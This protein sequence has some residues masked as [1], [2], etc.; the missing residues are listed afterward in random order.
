MA[1]TDTETARQSSLDRYAVLSHPAGRE[2]Q[3]LVEL[4]AQ[5]CDVPTAAINIVTRDRQHQIATAG[6]D[7]SVCSRDDSMCA[8]VLGEDGPVVVPDA[9]ADPRFA[10]NAFVNGDIG[11]VRFYAS[12]PLVTPEGTMLGRLCVFDDIARELSPRQQDALT[13]LAAQIMDVLELRY[14]T[15]ALE[16]SLREL[17]EVRDALRRSNEHLTLFA[18]QVSHDLRTPLTA[19]LVNAEVLAGEPVIRDNADATE[20]VKAVQTAGHR[21][22]AMIEEMLTFALEG[23]RL[24]VVETDLRRVVDLV[25]SDIAPML[26]RDRADVRVGDLPR[27]MGDHDLLY[28]VVLNLLTNAVKFARPGTAPT[29][30]IT[31]DRRSEHWRVRVTDDGIGVPAVRR[32]SM[33]ALFARGGEGVGHG[34]GLATARRIVEAHGGSIGMD[35]P[36]GGGTS[37]WFDLPV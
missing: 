15:R 12:A 25:L 32:E 21:M 19:I 7:P 3:A 27:V 28:S 29:V 11:R 23:G 24:Q 37:V 33:F 26:K 30:S 17:T 4:V 31:A 5:T 36:D 14:R 1:T 18:G 22:D 6:F 2:L 16:E 8:L 10:R 20:M 13:T 34:I 35:S 9:S